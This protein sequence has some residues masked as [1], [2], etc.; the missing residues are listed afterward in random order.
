MV[1]FWY[2]QF[3]SSMVPNRGAFGTYHI[4]DKSILDYDFQ[5]VLGTNMVYQILVRVNKSCSTQG[6][7]GGGQ[8]HY[9]LELENIPK[10]SYNKLLTKGDEVSI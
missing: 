10:R 1:H 3:A 2:I 4:H 5:Y 9:N 6:E 7:G 8:N